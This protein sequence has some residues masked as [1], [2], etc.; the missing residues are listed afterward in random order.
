MQMTPWFLP[1]VDLIPARVYMKTTDGRF[2]FMN[3]ACR[4]SLRLPENASFE[5]LTDESFFEEALALDWRREEQSVVGD[6]ECICC[7]R[8]EVE[9]WKDGR[10]SYVRTWKYAVHG[11]EGLVIFGVSYDVTPEYDVD[12]R[13]RAAVAAAND[14]FWY[15]DL[16][17]GDT[18]LS[19]RWK[20]ILGYTEGE[21]VDSFESVLNHVVENDRDRF[22]ESVRGLEQSNAETYDIE[23]QMSR[24]DGTCCQIRSRGMKGIDPL[25]GHQFIAGSHTDI[26]KSRSTERFLERIVDAVPG[27]IFCKD[28]QRR[29]TFVNRAVCDAFGKSQ[30]EL[31]GKRDDEVLSKLTPEEISQFRQKD[32]EVIEDG[33]V[34]QVEETFQ[35]I[36][37]DLVY[38]QTVKRPADEHLVLNGRE[39]TI[40]GVSTDVTSKVLER[41][42]A[43]AAIEVERSRLETIL[44]SLPVGV[45]LRTPSR[46]FAFANQY[47][48]NVFR[49]TDFD[50]SQLSLADV[51]GNEAA[52]QIE[53]E[54]SRIFQESITAEDIWRNIDVGGATRA[55][56]VS[57]FLLPEAVE[58]LLCG[59]LK[60]MTD[61]LLVEAE[62]SQSKILLKTMIDAVRA[63]IFAKDAD[64][65][66]IAVNRAFLRRHGF[67]TEDEVIGKRD[68]DF[69]SNDDAVAYRTI[70]QQVIATGI[71]MEWF[72]ESQHIDGIES[73]IETSK[74]PLVNESGKVIGVVG[75][76]DEADR[77][78][79][80][81]AMG[82]HSAAS[83]IGVCLH[84]WIRLLENAIEDLDDVAES[85][86]LT[87]LHEICDYMSNSF[88]QMEM[89][90]ELVNWQTNRV[91]VQQ[92]LKQL[93]RL[94][95]EKPVAVLPPPT[96]I[97][98]S[99]DRH[100]LVASLIALVDNSL[101]HGI[102][103]LDVGRVYVGA[104]SSQ[105]DEFDGV[106]FFVDD[107]GYGFDP[108]ST[109]LV[110]ASPESLYAIGF[111]LELVREFVR[112]CNG[113]VR[114]SDSEFKKEC[115]GRI[116]CR[117]EVFVPVRPR[118]SQ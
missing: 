22:L 65:K 47:L 18:W 31:I 109:T 83:R 82:A 60:E 115:G 114:F 79:R 93:E 106:L 42:R 99:C 43:K 63:C 13:Y 52:T 29:F 5:E 80:I 20:E 73:R 35:S 30:D 12:S 2:L 105:A 19:K 28:R 10:V 48:R 24:K 92:T 113:E 110:A 102:N 37:G 75:I 90:S 104:R 112:R 100:R 86:Q 69:N 11:P 27:F 39:I 16:E 87:H 117:V 36:S 76:Y 88:R 33:K 55:F 54:D 103:G 62:R 3:R 78:D 46:P 77:I 89:V 17:T 98:A 25:T 72:V 32:L 85:R 41:E 116:G 97:F 68:S 45:F 91:S 6:G 15:R 21:F 59:V 7:N 96:E 66:Y 74:Y 57:K 51:V 71:A 61:I 44:D 38:L 58:P 107:T 95:R 67:K 111:G 40:I 1:L 56:V 23:F 64:L 84:R 9:K 34:V 4:E 81:K 70:D 108:S 118:A 50:D 8:F 49:D 53:R 14:G 101:R 26:T 94:F